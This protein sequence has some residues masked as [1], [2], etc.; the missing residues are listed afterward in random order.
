PRLCRGGAPVTGQ[1][2]PV[3]IAAP[4]HQ[5]TPAAEAAV[6]GQLRPVSIA[7]EAVGWARVPDAN[8]RNRPIKAG[9][10]CGA[11]MRDHPG[12]AHR[13]AVTGQLR[14]VSI[15]ALLG[16]GLPVPARVGPVT[17]Q[18]RPVSIAAL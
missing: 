8:P 4:T 12:A 13:P 10:H 7:A 3:S 6:T 17:G 14:P 15:A 11:E 16:L 1:L 5:A 18:L 2:R 9:L